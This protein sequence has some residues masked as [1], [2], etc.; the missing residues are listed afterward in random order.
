VSLEKQA[1]MRAQQEKQ[2]VPEF[3]LQGTLCCVNQAGA[4]R[5]IKP[6]LPEGVQID[7]LV[8]S[9]ENLYARVNPARHGS[10]F[11]LNAQDVNRF[12]TL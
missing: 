6:K 5:V 2:L 4:S 9:D 1:E 8:P 11:E 10:I 3:L 7:V 12:K